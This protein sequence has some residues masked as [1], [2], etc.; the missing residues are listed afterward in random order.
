MSLFRNAVKRA[1]YIRNLVK[2]RDQLLVE[3]G[4]LQNDI[5][6]LEVEI[7]GLCQQVEQLKHVENPSQAEGAKTTFSTW[8]ED[9]ILTFLFMDMNT[10]FYVDVGAYHPTLHSNTKLLFDRGWTGIN[11]DCNPL[12][13][14]IF[15][16]IRPRDVNLN[17]A[18][19]KTE[20]P[21]KFL[22]FNDWGTSNTISREFGEV[23]SRGQNVAIQKEVEVNSLTLKSILDK[24]LPENRC[25]DFLNIDVEAVDLEVLQS[26]DWERYRPWVIAIEDLEFNFETNL[27]DSQINTYLRTLSYKLVSRTIYTS[28]YVDARRGR[29][30]RGCP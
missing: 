28:V 17:A 16:Q 18:V 2:Q 5:R 22:M 26:N 3:R 25:I 23:I 4:S 21:V 12:M 14:D 1:P 30:L 7:Q 11:I 29:A 20:G 15:N 10:G 19:S 8:G 24:N 9:Q 27:E 6:S 13:I